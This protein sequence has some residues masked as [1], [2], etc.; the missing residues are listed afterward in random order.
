M[1]QFIGFGDGHDGDA[2]ISGDPNTRT[3]CSGS[4]GATTL[5]VASTSGFQVGDMVLIHQ[6]RGAGAGN[7]ELNKITNIGSGELTLSNPLANNYTDS[8]ASQAQCILVPQYKNLTITGGS[9][10]NWNGNTGGIYVVM[11]NSKVTIS[12]NITADGGDNGATG[13]GFKGGQTITGP[14]YCGEGTAADTSIKTS[15]NGNGG[16]GGDRASGSA[17]GGA[18]GGNGEAGDNG[19]AGGPGTDPGDGGNTSG[20][21]DLTTMDLGG[22]GGGASPANGE[23]RYS[24]GGGGGIVVIIAKEIEITGSISADGG[25]S[26]DVVGNTAAGSGGGAGG[27]ILIKAETADIGTDKI[28][29]TGGVG[30]KATGLSDADGGDGG[31]GRIRVEACSLAGSTNS[32][33]ASEVEGGHDWCGAVT[34][35]IGG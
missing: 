34:G 4:S 6:S 18:G 7:W 8:G 13:A 5:T 26:N 20:S 3:S 12:G 22:G 23:T 29:A 27:S 10:A 25:T 11:S 33:S 24:A 17:A 1:S 28:T 19:V 30:G 31:D 32:P 35:V 16:G 2:S 21:A 9:P 15:A 14:A